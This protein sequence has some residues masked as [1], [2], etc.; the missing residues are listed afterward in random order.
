MI[1]ILPLEQCSLPFQ[2]CLNI[3]KEAERV[4]MHPIPKRIMHQST[5]LRHIGN[6]CI[7]RSIRD[8]FAGRTV[9]PNRN[10]FILLARK[11]Q[12]PFFT[13]L[14]CPTVST[15]FE[16]LLLLTLLDRTHSFE[17]QKHTQ[18]PSVTTPSSHFYTGRYGIETR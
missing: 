10:S 12:I 9:C 15:I 13:T 18:R 3:S 7:C 4:H 14:N 16:I 11:I 17:M 8:S 5:R 6:C 2:I 1:G